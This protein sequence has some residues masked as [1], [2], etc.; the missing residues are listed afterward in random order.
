MPRFTKLGKNSD[1]KPRAKDERKP[2]AH[3]LYTAIGT[4]GISIAEL[5]AEFGITYL[6]LWKW[7]NDHDE[8]SNVAETLVK[9]M[10]S[11]LGLNPDELWGLRSFFPKRT[12]TPKQPLSAPKRNRKHRLSRDLSKWP[13]QLA[14]EVSA[15]LAVKRNRSEPV[16]QP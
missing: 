11:R 7:A 9:N 13:F 12:K 4:N 3:M 1:T 5:A 10:A 14:T 6:K 8:P 16:L 2:F 15:M